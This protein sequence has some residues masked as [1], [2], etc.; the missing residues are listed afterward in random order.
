MTYRL[1]PEKEGGYLIEVADYPPAYSEG[2]T[3]DEALTMIE[4]AL[5]LVLEVDKE[6]GR[7]IPEHLEAWLD[8]VKDRRDRP[9]ES[10]SSH[11]TYPST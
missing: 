2:R 9:A 11:R 8:R 10:S 4:D 1:T 3:I 7:T 6:D 5:Q